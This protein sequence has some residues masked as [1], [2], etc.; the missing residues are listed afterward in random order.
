M[1]ELP[2]K[3]R[4]I[5]R[6]TVQ[7]SATIGS[8]AS[9]AISDH[10]GVPCQWNLQVR[11]LKGLPLLMRGEPQLTETTRAKDRRTGICRRGARGI[12]L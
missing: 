5:T 1:Q 2:M 7:K 10:P 6:Q 11:Q 8:F 3:T 12:K 4:V 9:G